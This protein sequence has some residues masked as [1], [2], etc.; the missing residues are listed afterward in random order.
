MV[1]PG[2]STGYPPRM[3][4]PAQLALDVVALLALPWVILTF[5]SKD[6]WLGPQWAPAAAMLPPVA[7]TLWRRFSS[8]KASPLSPL[9]LGSLMVNAGLGFVTLD[10]AWFAVKEAGVPLAMALVTAA[11]TLRGPGLIAAMLDDVLDP[12]RLAAALHGRPADLLHA[13]TRRSTLAFA[14]VFLANGAISA[15]VARWLVTAPSGSS[16]FAEQLGTYTWWSFVLVNLP[17]MAGT[18]VVLRGVLTAIEAETGKPLE[19]LLPA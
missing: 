11:T 4:R 12:E 5:G 15:G 3:S 19:E 10:A 9:V 13:R 7:H 1:D 18:V 8:G 6:A 17:T 14:A 16:L 2:P